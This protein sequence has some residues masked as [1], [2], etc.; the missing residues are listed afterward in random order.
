[1]KLFLEELTNH[2]HKR[3]DS[4]I[5]SFDLASDDS[6]NVVLGRQVTKS[7]ENTLKTLLI[8]VGTENSKLLP[9]WLMTFPIIRDYVHYIP[10]SNSFVSEK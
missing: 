3:T 10:G 1:M 9:I 5:I 4:A 8:F 7:F 2:I 6:D